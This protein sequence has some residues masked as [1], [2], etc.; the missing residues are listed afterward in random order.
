MTTR[1]SAA[2]HAVH[3]GG[4]ERSRHSHLRPAAA[5]HVVTN[6]VLSRTLQLPNGIA[7]KLR[8]GLGSKRLLRGSLGLFD[9]SGRR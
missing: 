3:Y 4:T 5:Q 1:F 8:N 2:P 7:W 9:P 6:E